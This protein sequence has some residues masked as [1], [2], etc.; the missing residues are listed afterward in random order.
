MGLILEKL[1]LEFKEEFPEAVEQQKPLDTARKLQCPYTLIRDRKDIII[2]IIREDILLISRRIYQKLSSKLSRKIYLVDDLIRITCSE[3]HIESVTNKIEIF[4]NLLLT[5]RC[6]E[7]ETRYLKKNFY[8]DAC[9][10]I[11]SSNIKF[12]KI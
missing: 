11:I 6:G 5:C 4:F 12:K 3:Y 1:I 2:K 9:G 8:C 7:K 10:Y